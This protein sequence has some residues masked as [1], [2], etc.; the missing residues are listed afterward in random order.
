[1]SFR[2]ITMSVVLAFRGRLPVFCLL[3]IVGVASYVNRAEAQSLPGWTLVWSDE[4]DGP[5]IDLSKWSHEVNGQGGGNNELQYYTA[6][7]TNSFIE[8]GKLVIQALKESYTGPDGTRD[9]T[10]ARLRTLNKGD[11]KYG[12]FEIRARTPTGRGLWPAIWMLPTDWVYGGWAASGEIDIM[13]SGNFASTFHTF[14]IE[15]ETNAFRWYVDGLHYWTETNWYSTAAPYPAPFN[16]RFHMLLNVAVGGN[17]PGPPDGSTVFPQRMEVDYVR[18]YTKGAPP[19]FSTNLLA[20]PGFETGT[21]GWT[22]NA[23][24]G[25]VVDSTAYARSGSSSLL[26]DNAGA[27]GWAAPQALQS[28]AA[29]PGQV[30]NFQGY[31]RTPS[32]ITD[33]SFGLLKVVFKDSG[34]ND[35]VPASAEIGNIN[36]SFP[37]IESTPF[38]N[39]A[40]PASQWVFTQAKGKAPAGTTQVLFFLLNVNPPG[41]ATSMYLDDI[42]ANL[43]GA[44]PLPVTL[45]ATQVGN[46]IQISFP[47]QNGASYDVAYKVNLTDPN[48]TPIVTIS[49][50]GTTKT[51]SYP[52]TAP[53]RFYMVRTP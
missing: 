48:W 5:N 28:F 15:W 14:A 42:E 9:Y 16:Q 12:R 23:S 19:V 35:L 24:G 3:L 11:W 44:P 17:W 6:R 36:T 20:N 8:N 45:T 13:P 52:A 51:V 4:F 26:L 32:T 41:S 33:G 25:T 50:D 1:M 22:V 18:V 7:A 37:G 2:S 31:M 39:G 30:F 34:G 53:S 46:N 47:T 21:T 27:A 40:S 43:V 29:S 49:G 10:S 38:L